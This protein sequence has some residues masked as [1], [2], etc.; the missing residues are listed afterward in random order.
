MNGNGTHC[1]NDA[2]SEGQT[3]FTFW[4]FHSSLCAR[5][6]LLLA[7]LPSQWKPDEFAQSSLPQHMQFFELTCG[8]G[9][10]GGAEGEC[11]YWQNSVSTDLLRGTHSSMV[12]QGWHLF[13]LRVLITAMGHTLYTSGGASP[14]I[15]SPLSSPGCFLTGDSFFFF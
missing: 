1:S 7:Y 13:L 15:T 10:V 3:I 8:S 11:P 14:W 4:E 12:S 2:W 9:D 5:N 6:F